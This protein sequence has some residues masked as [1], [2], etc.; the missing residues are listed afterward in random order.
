MESSYTQD[1]TW[2]RRRR[3]TSRR[4]S[5]GSPRPGSVR[6]P[7]E[8]GVPGTS[9]E[10]GAWSTA[11]KTRLESPTFV[12]RDYASSNI[13]FL[14]LGLF[15]VKRN[16][17]FSANSVLGLNSKD[18]FD[19]YSRSVSSF[20]ENHIECFFGDHRLNSTGVQTLDALAELPVERILELT[21]RQPE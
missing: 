10:S 18:I 7:C 5:D 16:K 6:L 17:K 1:R 19:L 14:C 13:S 9:K 15:Q 4:G 21:A 12:M 3:K 20:F 2:Y 8:K 11:F